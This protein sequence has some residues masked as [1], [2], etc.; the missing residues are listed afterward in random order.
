M[1]TITSTQN[2]GDQQKRLREPAPERGPDVDLGLTPEAREKAIGLM[3]VAL[4]NTSLLTIKTKKFHWDVVGPQ[5]MTL[6]E[7]WDEQYET[8]NLYADETAERIRMLGGYPLGTAQGFLHATELK[9]HPGEIPSATEAVSFLVDDHETIVRS[10]RRAID[11][12]QD[13]L[14]DAGTAD[15]LTGMLRGHEKMA[16]MLRS[17]LTGS[18]LR[19]SG[20]PAHGHVPR[21]A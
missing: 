3:N 20:E 11:A 10:L 15:F 5:F 18:A 4:A 1:G 8:L 9:E 14:K 21:D 16:W 6:H 7:L 17:F 12:C 19:G 2:N 13:D